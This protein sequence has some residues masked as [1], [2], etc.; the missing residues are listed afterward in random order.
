MSEQIALEET[1]PEQGATGE[2]AGG[3]GGARGGKKR[4]PGK[5]SVGIEIGGKQY[6]VRSDADEGWLH[7]LASAVDGAMRQIRDRTDTVDSHE[8]AVLTALNLARELVDLRDQ[9]SAIRASDALAGARLEGLDE[10]GGSVVPRDRL[11]GLIERVELSL[12]PRPS[13]ADS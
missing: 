1:G 6:R 7:R 13:E 10:D 8:I 3:K 5:R 11:R 2:K 4:A 9:L 12:E